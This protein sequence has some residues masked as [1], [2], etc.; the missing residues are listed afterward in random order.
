VLTDIEDIT[1]FRMHIDPYG[2]VEFMRES[3]TD[4]DG[5]M[6]N[7]KLELRLLIK[8]LPAMLHTKLPGYQR[9]AFFLDVKIG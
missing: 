7:D 9:G 8:S 5:M 4:D 2:L 6:P 3:I 1:V